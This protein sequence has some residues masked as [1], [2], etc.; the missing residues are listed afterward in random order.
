MTNKLV[1]PATFLASFAL[2]AACG[3]GSTDSDGTGGEGGEDGSGGGDTVSSGG[4]TGGQ[5]LGGGGGEGGSLGGGGPIII[6]PLTCSDGEQNESETDVDCGGPDCDPC[7]DD[8]VC[9]EPTDCDS[10][11]CTDGVC[12]APTC[13]DGVVNGDDECDPGRETDDC[14]EDC[15]FT[16]CG[17]GY[18]NARAEDCEPDPDQGIWQSCGSTCIIGANLDGT[19]REDELPGAN[20]PW[21]SLTSS[22]ANYGYVGGLQSFHYASQAFLYDLTASQRYDIKKDEWSPL[23]NALPYAPLFWENA[24]VDGEALWVPRASSMFRLDLETLEWTTPST[25]IP[26]GGAGVTGSAAVY[27]SEGYI[28]Y[29]GTDSDSAEDVL[30]KYDPGDG[31]FQIFSW[32]ATHP[33]YAAHEPRVAYDPVSD[34]VA[35]ASYSEESSFLIFDP[36]DEVFT[37]GASL[38]DGGYVTDNTCQDRAGGVYITSS[39]GTMFRYDI[40]LDNYMP[41]PPLPATND[42]GSTCVVSEVGYLYYGSVNVD[43]ATGK[44]GFLRLRLNTR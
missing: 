10:G 12:I 25:D 27:D 3:G 19:W 24:A 41:L 16:V 15:T 4:S 40:A 35:F 29:V 5:N 32:L 7:D 17:D 28:W 13:G 39:Y 34:Q 37:Q 36:T 38:P 11:V 43:P 30:V 21:E 6:V 31:G 9:G 33:D 42:S 44:N 18:L 23:P 8:A 1:W 2:A 22:S 26:D 14:D 20:T